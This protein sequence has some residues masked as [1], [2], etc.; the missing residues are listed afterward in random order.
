MSASI[1]HILLAEEDP[2]FGIL[3]RDYFEL[4]DYRV[5]LCKDECQAITAFKKHTFDICIMDVMIPKKYDSTLANEIKKL[6]TN[7]P[8]IFLTAKTLEA[9]MLEGFT[10]ETYNCITKP[11]DFEILLYKM[12]AILNRKEVTSKEESKP[13]EYVIGQYLFQPKLRQL[14]IKN[15][16]RKLSPKES[17]L[18]SLLCHHLNDMLPREMALHRIWHEESYFT[19]RS[20]D[21]YIAK[22]RKYLKDDTAVE[23]V[24]LH[25]QG[26]RLCV[27][28]GILF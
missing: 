15:S 10:I 28:N 12:K 16:T 21:V 27:H 3:L 5:T 17:E 6:N 20:M 19:A 4:Y 7:I 2:K 25:G 8:I 9:L 14:H 1:K 24:N 18:L 13:E 22:L 23:I 26:Y 11:F